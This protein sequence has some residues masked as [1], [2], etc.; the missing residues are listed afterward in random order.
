MCGL[1]D[2]QRQESPT[3][4]PA[5]GSSRLAARV[6]HVALLAE[7]IRPQF[8]QNHVFCIPV[9]PPSVTHSSVYPPCLANRGPDPGSRA[10]AAVGSGRWIS[11]TG[12]AAARPHH[13]RDH[14][15]TSLSPVIDDEFAHVQAV[16]A[17]FV[18]LDDTEAR[19]PDREVTDD[20]AAKG[21]RPIATAP[22][23]KAPIARPPIPCAPI[24]WAPI[25]LAGVR[26]DGRSSRCFFISRWY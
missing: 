14:R 5:H 3:A 1:C 15:A 16:D 12:L 23:A 21:E 2:H 11:V 26:V 25:A 6:D 10:G 4:L 18:D 20:Q 17:E 24:A 7:T 8:R 9:T 22:T 13:P 19:A